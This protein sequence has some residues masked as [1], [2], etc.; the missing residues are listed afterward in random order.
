MYTFADSRS[1]WL[2]QL[3]CHIDLLDEMIVGVLETNKTSILVVKDLLDR[4]QFKI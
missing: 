2:K 1:H 4:R 3:F